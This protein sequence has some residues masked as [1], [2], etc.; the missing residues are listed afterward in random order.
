MAAHVRGR[1]GQRLKL[2]VTQLAGRRHLPI[3]ELEKAA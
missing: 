1:R 3:V 2:I